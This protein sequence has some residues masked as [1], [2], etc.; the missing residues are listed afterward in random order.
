MVTDEWTVGQTENIMP[1]VAILACRRHIKIPYILIFIE[2]C[3]RLNPRILNLH[4]TNGDFYEL[5]CIICN[6]ILQKF[7]HPT[8]CGRG[9]FYPTLTF[10]HAKLPKKI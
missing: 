6:I 1:R 8:P 3:F 2:I 4:L 9:Q 5:R 10:R 7:C